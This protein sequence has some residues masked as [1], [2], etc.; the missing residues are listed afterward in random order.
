[1]RGLCRVIVLLRPRAGQWPGRTAFGAGGRSLRIRIGASVCWRR[2]TARSPG[3]VESIRRARRQAASDD[4]GSQRRLER[5]VG[6][7]APDIY[8][9]A[10]NVDGVTALDPLTTPSTATATSA[11]SASC[12][13][14][15]TGRSSTT[16]SGAARRGADP[17]V[18][19]E[20]TRRQQDGVGLHAARL[21][22]RQGLPVLYLLH[23][24]GD[25]E[26]GWTMIGRANNILD[27]L[28]AE[29]KAGRWSW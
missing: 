5:T 14:P 2:P 22:S 18:H 17:S 1:M 11:R 15:A 12:R 25:I 13:C 27:N 26:S 20:D 4:E 24:A 23:G 29:K 28:I 10:F 7:L 3:R 16:S 9:Y 8:T 19:V 6:P 21:R